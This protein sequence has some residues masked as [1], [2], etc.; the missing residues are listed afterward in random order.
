MTQ[1]KLTENIVDRYGSLLLN[2]RE[3]AKE[4]RISVNQLDRLRDSGDI[5]FS[6]VGSQIRISASVIADF[7]VG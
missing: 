6:K 4:L 3:A 2:K 1:E 5:K 7:M